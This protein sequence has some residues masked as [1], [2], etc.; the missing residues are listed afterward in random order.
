MTK[1]I[2]DNQQVTIGMD[3]KR[4]VRNGTGLGSYGRTL[5]NSLSDVDADDRFLLYAPDAGRD[6]LR[7]QVEL[8]GGVDFRYPENLHFRLQRDLWRSHGIV[9]DLRKDGVLLFHG[10][11]GELPV[12]LKESGI[13]GLVTIHDLIFLRH[14]EYF[15]VID[16]WIYKRKFYKTL[17][18]ATRIV[19]ISECTKR[20]I[21]YYSDYPEDQIDLIYQSCGQ[22]FK[23]RVDDAQ[24]TATRKKYQLPERY[25]LN[26]GTIEERKNILEGVLALKNLPEYHL[27]IVGRQTAYT[28]KT[29]KIAEREGL[30]GRIHL[31]SGVPNDDLYAIYQQAECFIYPSRYEGFG[32]PIIEAIQ[33]GLPVVAATGSC[34][35]EAGGPDCL[36]VSPDD[37]E[38]LA[39]AIR[40]VVEER[41]GR[42][43]KAQEY[44]RRFENGDIASSMLQEYAMMLENR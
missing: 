19:A 42:V 31:L 41:E 15:P 5:V 3:A 43:E 35:E 21:L 12:G 7:T 30:A 24:K 17:R 8:R 36:Y 22:R 39:A 13:P 25:I 27:V 28:R 18:E 37:P 9:K 29:M 10:L 38:A 26:V 2:L 1:T 40:K 33:S 4:I 34:L 14:P 32:I 20:D 16:A 23:T 11:S 44:V 6:H